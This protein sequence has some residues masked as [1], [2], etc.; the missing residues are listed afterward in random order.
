MFLQVDK[1]GGIYTT[2]PDSPQ[3][4]LDLWYNCELNFVQHPTGDLL[5]IQDSPLLTRATDDVKAAFGDTSFEAKS[6]FVMTYANYTADGTADPPVRHL[7][8]RNSAQSG[9]VYSEI[10]ASNRNV[11]EIGIL[12][13]RFE[14]GTVRLAVPTNL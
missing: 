9:H 10:W 14:V 6:V 12:T 8:T 13:V 2:I 3:V 11:P 4:Y 7:R 1:K 5:F